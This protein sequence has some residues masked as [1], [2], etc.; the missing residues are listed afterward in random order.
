MAGKNPYVQRVEELEERGDRIADATSK[1]IDEAERMNLDHIATS[2]HIQ[3]R[4]QEAG[5]VPE[6]DLEEMDRC[7]RERDASQSE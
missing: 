5:L 1:A 6:C 3:R 4:L 2:V 7:L